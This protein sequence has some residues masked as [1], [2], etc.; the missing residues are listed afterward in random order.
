MCAAYTAVERSNSDDIESV[1]ELHKDRS[2]T[3][4]KSVSIDEIEL[5]VE[6]FPSTNI[7]VPK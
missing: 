6:W 7:L 5:L 2:N 1:E 4:L 3:A